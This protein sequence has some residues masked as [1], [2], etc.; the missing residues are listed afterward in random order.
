[1]NAGDENGD[2]RLITVDPVTVTVACKATAAAA[3][4]DDDETE[5]IVFFSPRRA[6]LQSPGASSR[7]FKWTPVN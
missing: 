7:C 3:D 1:M 2:C 6:H 4:D 5:A